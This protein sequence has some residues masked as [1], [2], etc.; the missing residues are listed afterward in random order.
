[1]DRVSANPIFVALFFVLRC[2]IPLFLMLG[3]TALL[4]KLG[5]VAP[6]PEEPQ[7][8]TTQNLPKGKKKA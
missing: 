4:R 3:V 7:E 5:L 2:A 8:Q 1:M 6:P